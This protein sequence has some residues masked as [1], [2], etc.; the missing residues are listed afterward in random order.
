MKPV[1]C[2][3]Q[4][5]ERERG[6]QLPGQSVQTVAMEAALEEATGTRSERATAGDGERILC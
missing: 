3:E 1:M 6:R 4:A 2:S 5:V